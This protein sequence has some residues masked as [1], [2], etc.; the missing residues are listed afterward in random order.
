MVDQQITKAEE[1]LE[2]FDLTAA[3]KLVRKRFPIG[4]I[5]SDEILMTEDEAEPEIKKLKF[6]AGE[7]IES[8]MKPTE[9]TQAIAASPPAAI[10]VNKLNDSVS[11]PVNDATVSAP[12]VNVAKNKN[13]RGGRQRN[14]KPTGGIKPANND[15]INQNNS[16][17]NSSFDASV[18]ASNDFTRR[19]N[20]N[21]SNNS[22]KE[23][24]N[25]LRDNFN[26]LLETYD[27]GDNYNRNGDNF[28]RGGNNYNNNR[29]NDFGRNNDGSGNND[30]LSR[31]F[32]NNSFNSSG[33]GRFNSRF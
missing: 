15:N 29:S 8:E 27:R 18:G 16:Y 9:N 3:A 12:I 31:Y 23:V 20:R 19:P 6:I 21:G 4:Q 5:I 32:G 7:P 17:K 10:V 14:G 2:N 1:S 11:K 28:G 13:R 33:G 22:Y 30:N 26:R 24:G 25:N